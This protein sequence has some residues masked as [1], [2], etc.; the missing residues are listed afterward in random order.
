MSPTSRR[1]APWARRSLVAVN[2]DAS[3]R[4]LGKGADRPLK[5]WRTALAVVAALACVGA[6]TWFDETRPSG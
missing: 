3:A 4:R 2:G 1:R 5:A 6:V